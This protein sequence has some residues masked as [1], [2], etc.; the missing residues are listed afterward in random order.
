MLLRALLYLPLSKCIYFITC[1]DICQQLKSDVVAFVTEY[2][3]PVHKLCGH[4]S[5]MMTQY[6]SLI[7]RETS[8]LVVVEAMVREAPLLYCLVR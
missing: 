6:A 1:V 5:I 3:Y 2:F 7:S 8:I 4:L